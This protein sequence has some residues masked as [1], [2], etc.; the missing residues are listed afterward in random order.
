MVKQKSAAQKPTPKLTYTQRGKPL[1]GEEFDNLVRD[2][3]ESGYLTPEEFKKK[4]QLLL[5]FK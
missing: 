4:C 2:A 1:T 5:N 3:D